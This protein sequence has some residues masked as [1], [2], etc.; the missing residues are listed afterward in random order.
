MK[1]AQIREIIRRAMWTRNDLTGG[2]AEEFR[3]QDVGPRLEAKIAELRALEIAP[4][5]ADDIADRDAE[6]VR[7]EAVIARWNATASDT[8]KPHKISCGCCTGIGLDPNRPRCT[9][10]MHRR[11]GPSTVCGYHMAEITARGLLR[12]G[13]A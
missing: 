10:F 6:I 1:I 9:C 12:D 8:P 5:F 7:C 13:A 3:K 2:T 4:R 11:S